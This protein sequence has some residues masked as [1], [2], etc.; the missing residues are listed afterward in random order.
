[1]D[2]QTT[3]EKHKKLLRYSQMLKIRKIRETQS[4][5]SYHLAYVQLVTIRKLGNAELEIW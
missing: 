1:M 4:F 3:E 2:R 5:V